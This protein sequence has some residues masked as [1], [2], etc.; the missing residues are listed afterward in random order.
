MLDPV[1]HLFP[2]LFI[3]YEFT[4]LFPMVD[5]WGRNAKTQKVSPTHPDHMYGAG[6]LTLI[7]P[8]GGGTHHMQL[9]FNSESNNDVKRL[10]W[11]TK[12]DQNTA[13]ILVLEASYNIKHN[14]FV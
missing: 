11:Q 10:R 4:P 3:V 14:D 2:I 6:V 7:G 13:A 9:N 1:H 8:I 5:I 12:C